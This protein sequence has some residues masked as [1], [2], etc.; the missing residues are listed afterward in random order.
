VKN[1]WILI[2]LSRVHCKK[3]G[4]VVTG[5]AK[6]VNTKYGNG[7]MQDGATAMLNKGLCNACNE[8]KALG[9]GAGS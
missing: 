9:S 2:L 4:K 7:I 3:C 6:G 1:S 8:S 5:E